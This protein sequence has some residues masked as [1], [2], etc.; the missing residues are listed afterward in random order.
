MRRTW[1]NRIFALV[2]LCAIFALLYHHF[3]TL[4]LIKYSSSTSTSTTTVIFSLLILLADVVLAFMW[5]TY[6]G[7]RMAPIRRKVFPENLAQIV[8]NEGEYPALDVFICT[9]DPYKE[10]PMGVVNTALSVM[11]YDYPMEKLS[12][13]LSDDGCSQLTLFAFMEAAKFATHWLPYCRKNNLVD[14]CPEA[15][16]TSRPTKSLEGRDEIKI[17]YERMKDRVENVVERSG[18]ADYISSDEDA[19]KAFSKW[20]NNCDGLTRQDHPAIIQVLLESSIHRDLAGHAM[21]NLIYVSREKSTTT[22][23]HYKAGALNMLLRVSA[24]MT[25][26]PIILTLDCD[27]YSNDPRTPLRALCYHLDP[28][29]NS[30]LAFVQFPQHFHGINKDDIYGAEFKNIV[31][32]NACGLDG[33]LGVNYIGSGTF[34][35]RRAFFGTPLS[36][37]LPEIPELSPHQH[38]NKPISAN[39]VLALAHQVAGCR[40]D[41]Q[42]K[43]GSEVGFKYGSLVEDFYT[44]YRLHCEGWKSVLCYPDKS[45]FLGGAPITLHDLL[46]QTKRWAIGL[47][48][49]TF[50]KYNP[51]TFGIKS[52]NFF[53]ALCYTHYSFWPIWCIPLTIYAF[54]PQ[55]ALINSLPI[56]P[57]VS[58]PWVFLYAFLFIGAY[59]QD[60]LDFTLAGGT[61]RKWWNYQRSWMIRGL[62]SFIFALFEYLIGYFGVS[63]TSGFN[64]TS[65][66]VDDNEQTYRYEQGI[67]EFGVSSPMFI[68]ITM[69]AIINLVA[70]SSGI[71]R[72]LVM[73]NGSFENVFVQML[74]AGF[75]AVNSWPIYEAIVLRTDKGKMSVKITFI[76]VALAWLLCLAI[77]L[78]V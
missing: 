9:A 2:Y 56:F 48:D 41:A 17:M 53:Q 32:I 15:Y 70:F 61:V 12:V 63:G 29:I 30:E 6:Q 27:M 60:F 59:L 43:W 75:V 20:R 23:H 7:F 78:A 58:D 68:P 28:C 42:T 26:A 11:A 57:K 36:I 4:I 52:M 66:V 40:H 19:F 49:V 10:P 21:P 47:L 39:E 77:S 64:V 76:S 62:S 54:L 65:K 71:I 69:A 46:T 74:I 1:F 73:G 5:A 8:K 45:A 38:V 3:Q 51:I 34:F 24:I 44:G 50:C 14:R 16:F 35:Q 55:I 67:F 37:V 18:S 22:P 31:Q 72:V 33:L 13:Y 25:N